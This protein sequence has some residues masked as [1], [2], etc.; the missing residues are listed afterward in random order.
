MR[1][2]ILGGT[3]FLGRTLAED[4]LA[5]GWR[6]TCF[7][8]GRSGKDVPGV[9]SVR[10]DRTS[11]S[12][13]ERLT[14]HGPWDAVVD[15]SV[16]E[17]PDATLT[18]RT[19]RPVAGRYILVSTVSAYRNWP[20]QPVDESSPLWPSGR[21]ARETDD[22][23]AAM[24]VAH[25]YGTLKAGCEEAVQ[26]TYGDSALVLRPG[27]VLGPYEYVGRLAAL[28]GRAAR[29]GRILAAGD[30]GQPIQPVDVRDLAAFLL[31]LAATGVGGVF[32]VAAPKGHATH[33]DLLDAC[34]DVTGAPADLAWV[35]SDWLI[36][37]DVRQW[38]EIPLWRTPP[39]TWAV[40]PSRA[41]DAGLVC[42]PLRDTVADTW[43]WLQTERPVPHERQAE[44]GMDEE[45][46]AR[47]LAAWDEELTR[48]R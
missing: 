21:D 4:A 14:G 26:D 19:L 41:H 15:T 28:L 42:R 18:A 43:R 44:H 8:R 29:G 20:Q 13:V 36:E 30:P 1:L 48:R 38:T 16:Y 11:P 47:L 22:D 3:W 46:E 5:R 32:N 34:V 9:E 39:G 37:Q 12:D 10:G 40:D 23:V 17:P 6:V 2:L 7:N 25:S 31:D 27:V 33:G 45:K 24:P 35:D